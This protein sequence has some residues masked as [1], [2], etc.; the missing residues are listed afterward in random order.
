MDGERLLGQA[1]PVGGA[2]RPVRVLVLVVVAVPTQA[3]EGNAVFVPVEALG[4]VGEVRWHRELVGDGGR[5]DALMRGIDRLARGQGSRVAPAAVLDV[6]LIRA[7]RP[8]TGGRVVEEAEDDVRVQPVER[9]CD[10]E[11]ITPEA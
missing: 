4:R 3:L 7:V 9:S 5:F 8:C 10:L 2:E 6:Y 1:L 11:L